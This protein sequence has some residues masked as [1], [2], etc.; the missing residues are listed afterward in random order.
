MNVQEIIQLRLEPALKE[1]DLHQRR[2]DY[3]LRQLSGKI[4][5]DAEQW[6][7]LDDE[8]VA[9]I[10]QL[11][12]RYNKL[13]DAMGQRLFAAVLML[14]AEWREEQ[15]FLDKLDRLEKLGAIPSAEQWNEIRVIR[16]RMT[17]EYP[18]APEHNALNLNQVI[19]SIGGL[20]KTLAQIESYA[21]DLADRAQNN[22]LS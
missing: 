11:L 9:S 4:P 8:T 16:N 14:G 18:E 21:K 15:T 13:Q 2:L 1:C 7:S 12:F 22:T 3:A 10:D 19:E 5:L 17:H 6:N 20:K